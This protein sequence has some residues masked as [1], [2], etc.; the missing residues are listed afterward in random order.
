M[1]GLIGGFLVY[2]ILG[3]DSIEEGANI[4]MPVYIIQLLVELNKFKQTPWTAKE[5]RQI[6][7]M[8]AFWSLWFVYNCTSSRFSVPSVRL[9]FCSG[10]RSSQP[11]VGFVFSYYS[12]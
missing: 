11:F 1:I 6:L 3:P 9:P 10:D 2:C 12:R 5:R 8:L 7:W 4:L